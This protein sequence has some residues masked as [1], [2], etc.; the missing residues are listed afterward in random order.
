MRVTLLFL[1]L[2]FSSSFFGCGTDSKESDP[3]PT[4]KTLSIKA[5]DVSFLPEIETEGTLFYDGNGVTKNVLDLLKENGWNTVR[6]RVWHTPENAH[7]GLDEV[8]TFA[9]LARAKGFKIWITVHY[10][11]SWA[12]PGQQTKPASWNDL[13]F[14]VLADTVYRYTKRIVTNLNPDIIQIG[15]EINS[16]F[17]WPSGNISN[18]TNFT[19]LLKKGIQATR[20]F[21]PQSKI[22]IHYAGHASA[23][24]FYQ[25]LQ[26]QSVD[27][28]MI[29]LSYYPIWHGKDLTALQTNMNSLAFTHNKEI[30]IAET[31]YPFTLEWNDWT[32]NIV[33]ETGQLVTGYPATADGQKQFLLRIKQLIS[34]T[35]KG[36]GICYWAPEW[37]AFKGSEATN[38]SPWENMALFD[39]N[40]KALPAIEIFK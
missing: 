29:G 39:F 20:D 24:W 23:A 35:E 18:L 9:A 16:G 19:T 34:T 12:D 22:M 17:L 37:I 8:K 31:A 21:S 40:H 2:I 15:N 30:I 13:S 6:L 3:K 36:T 5:A 7:S 11:D 27:Y 10:S 4:P 28:D 33:G 1:I 32:N 14:S 25:Q 38:G 26:N